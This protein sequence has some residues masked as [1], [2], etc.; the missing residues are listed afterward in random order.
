[1]NKLDLYAAVRDQM[2]TGDLLQWSSNSVLGALIRWRTNAEVNHSGLVIR[3]QEYEGLERRRWT[4]EALEKGF[5]PNLL[6][7]RLEQFDGRVWWYPLKDELN[8]QRQAIGE[9]A[10]SMVGI[11]YDFLSIF[12]QLVGRVSAD[13]KHLFCSEG[14]Y[15]AYGF[16]G[17]APNPGEMPGLGIFKEPVLILDS[18]EQPAAF[19]DGK[20]S[21]DL[22]SEV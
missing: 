20:P 15:L 11:G 4:L 7:R 3:L 14:C 6:S 16:Q 18:T 21:T 9:R 5:Y 22:G 13:M 1:M 12:Q 8:G 10:F 19:P 2:K 17:T